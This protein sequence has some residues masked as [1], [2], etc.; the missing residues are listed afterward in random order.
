[1][2]IK[3]FIGENPLFLSH[4]QIPLAEIVAGIK[5]RLGAV[6][7]PCEEI[8]HLQMH[9]FNAVHLP[10]NE[11]LGLTQ[12]QLNIRALKIPITKK[13]AHYARRNFTSMV[14]PEEEDYIYLAF[15]TQVGYTYSN[16][17]KL[18]LEA[19]LAQ[20][21]SQEEIDQAGENY[22]CYL[23]YLKQYIGHYFAPF[24]QEEA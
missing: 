16:S 21:I 1:M 7:L 3:E 15:E 17:N 24:V 22:N 10:R 18:F 8:P 12:D 14:P 5:D 19:K 9:L 23:F 20:G 6:E 2:W 11:E 13:T 4:R